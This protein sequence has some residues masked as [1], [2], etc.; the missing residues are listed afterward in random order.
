MSESTHSCCPPGSAPPLVSDHKPHGKHI[1]LGSDLNTYH[2]GSGERAVIVCYEVFGMD[3]G[4]LRLI[5]DQLAHE[6][7]NVVMPDFYRNNVFDGDWGK[8]P[9]W[10]NETPWSKVSADLEERVYPFLQQQGV[11]KIGILGFCWGNWVVFHASATGRISAGASAH[12]SSIKISETLQEDYIG[13]LNQIKVP[14]LV[15]S[16]GNDSADLKDGGVYAEIL[17]KIPGTQTDDYSNQTHGWV[18]RGDLNNEEI[19][20]GVLKATNQIIQFFKK[21]VC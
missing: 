17:K 10:L 18:T 13:L 8:L 20:Q 14:Q 7:F 19:K 12:P 11:K 1:I 2:V 4:R 5:C 3:C 15:L 9:N 16:A 21:Y 6:G